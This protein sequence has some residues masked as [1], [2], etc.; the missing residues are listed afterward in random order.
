MG[1]RQQ[2]AV[3]LA[4]AHALERQQRA[5]E[6]RPEL[7]Q[8]R[9][10]PLARPTAMIISGTSALRPKNRARWRDAVGGAVDAEQ[11]GRAG[12]AAAVQ[13]VADATNAGAPPARSWR[14]T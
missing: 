6:Q 10:D 2:L 1:R 7:G 14:P 11:H 8:H 9:G 4:H 13:Q 5:R 12:D 3:A